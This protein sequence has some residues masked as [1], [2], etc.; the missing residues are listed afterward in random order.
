MVLVTTVEGKWARRRRLAASSC[1]SFLSTED[2][3]YHDRFLFPSLHWTVWSKSFHYNLPL[4]QSRKNPETKADWAGVSVSDGTKT[5]S[6]HFQRFTSDREAPPPPE[7]HFCL[8]L[9]KKK[10]TTKELS[11]FPVPSSLW[12]NVIHAPGPNS[13]WRRLLFITFSLNT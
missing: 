1:C 3:I 11:R 8:P 10:D 12:I 2:F 6:V 5:D 9:K 7:F 13:K 4:W